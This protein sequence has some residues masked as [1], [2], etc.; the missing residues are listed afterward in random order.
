MS[1]IFVMSPNEI[2]EKCDELL[3]GGVKVGNRILLACRKENCKHAIDEAETDFETLEGER[4]V[5]RKIM[6]NLGDNSERKRA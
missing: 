2:C 4:I 3:F 1:K 6:K 5:A